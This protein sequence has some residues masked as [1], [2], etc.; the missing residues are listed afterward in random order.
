MLLSG[1]E[2]ALEGVDG[3]GV[4]QLGEGDEFAC[5]AILA[6]EFSHGAHTLAELTQFFGFLRLE[7]FECDVV[8]VGAVVP[9][10]VE[11][12]S[13]ETAAY[14]GGCG[15]LLAGEPFGRVLGSERSDEVVGFE[16]SRQV[17]G[18]AFDHLGGDGT[19]QWVADIAGDGLDEQAFDVHDSVDG[20][21][22]LV[23]N[24]TNFFLHNDFF[25]DE[26]GLHR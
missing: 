15:E 5:R 10:F 17:L 14:L 11:G 3:E 23:D 9:V 1:E 19:H 20:E 26:H 13:G 4:G 25:L 22:H 2:G 16:Y 6:H 12:R 7:E 8:L 24:D 18:G 21:K